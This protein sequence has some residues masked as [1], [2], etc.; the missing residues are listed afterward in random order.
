MLL[1]WIADKAR[2]AGR[3]AAE[4]RHAELKAVLTEL[5]DQFDGLMQAV[6][7]YT[8]KI[9]PWRLEMTALAEKAEDLFDRARAKANRASA[10]KSYLEKQ[11]EQQQ[12]APWGDPNDEAAHV[13]WLMNQPNGL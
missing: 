4:E 12:Q 8:S 7:T 5:E 2:Q 11:Q 6:E 13:A 1:R 10:T 9:E 3:Q